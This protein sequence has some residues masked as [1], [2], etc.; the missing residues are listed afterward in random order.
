MKHPV[1]VGII[2]SQFISTIH[3][4]ALQR[5]PHVEIVAVSSRTRQHAKDFAARFSIPQTFTDYRQLLAE[6]G[7]DM[8]VVGMPSHWMPRR[9]ASTS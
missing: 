4:E 8:V 3:A 1:R 5:C 2:G 9:P 6:P 7:L